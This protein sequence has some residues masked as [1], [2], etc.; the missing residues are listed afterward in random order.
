MI[1]KNIRD[2]KEL[3]EDLKNCP[4]EKFKKYLVNNKIITK[5]EYEE[6]KQIDY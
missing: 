5:D 6:I 4:I 2:P 1:K 3:Q